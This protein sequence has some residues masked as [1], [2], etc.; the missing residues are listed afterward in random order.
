M[1]KKRTGKNESIEF[2]TA[3]FSFAFCA[4]FYHFND[5]TSNELYLSL[6]VWYALEQQIATH[7]VILKRTQF[8]AADTQLFKRLCPSVGPSVRWSVG[9]SV[10]EHESKSAK[11][12]VLDAFCVDGGWMPL[13]TRPQRYC[14]PATLFFD[15][16]LLVLMMVCLNDFGTLQ[17][18]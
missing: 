12:S 3:S 2:K 10:R 14:D 8:L 16:D 15:L 5:M 1:S 17:C 11:T 13:P 18:T 7:A 6:S 4:Q 9:P